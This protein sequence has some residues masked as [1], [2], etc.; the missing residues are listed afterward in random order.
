MNPLLLITV[1]VLGG[2][3]IGA[4]AVQLYHLQIE[5]QYMRR[6][7]EQRERQ[8]RDRAYWREIE[9]AAAQAARRRP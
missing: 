4:L 1:S 5:A 7:L 2:M 9:Q 8:A 6:V 3:A